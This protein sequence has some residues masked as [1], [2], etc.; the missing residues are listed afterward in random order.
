MYMKKQ[1]AKY[2]DIH[3]HLEH[4]RFENDLDKV[5]GK[6]EKKC[7]V[8]LL[9]VVSSLIATQ[10][11]EAR[12]LKEKIADCEQRAKFADRAAQRARGRDFSSYRRYIHMREAN[13]AQAQILKEKLAEIED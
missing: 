6:C 2:I 5:I 10:S 11:D 12:L 4:S 13:E 9:L 8:V 7:V 1:K 3:A